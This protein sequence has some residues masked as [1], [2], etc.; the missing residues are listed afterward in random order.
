MLP[1]DKDKLRE[2]FD[3]ELYEPITLADVQTLDSPWYVVRYGIVES[4]EQQKQQNHGKNVQNSKVLS[5]THVKYL[6][7]KARV[8]KAILAKN[9]QIFLVK[10]KKQQ[11]FSEISE[12]DY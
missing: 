6:N 12:Q 8:L 10:N 3:V 1:S 2:R 7:L 4:M 5:K 11:K 9:K